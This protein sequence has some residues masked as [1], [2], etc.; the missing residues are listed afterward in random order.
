MGKGAHIY[1]DGW[2][3]DFGGEHD[4]VS[5]HRR[6]LAVLHSCTML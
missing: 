3:L 1:R 5:T 6:R 4:V 2:K